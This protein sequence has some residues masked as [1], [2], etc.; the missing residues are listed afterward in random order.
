MIEAMA[1]GTPVIAFHSGSVPEVI[2]HGRS[3]FIVSSVEQAAEAVA[4]LDQIDRREV[5]AAFERR[6]TVER[7]AQDYLGIF[8]ILRRT[9][10]ASS[11]TSCSAG[12]MPRP[13]GSL[14]IS[15]SRRICSTRMIP[16][17]SDASA[18]HA[19]LHLQRRPCSS[20]PKASLGAGA[21]DSTAQG[22]QP[23][24]IVR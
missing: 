21:A 15:S 9:I 8:G 13:S 7:M 17:S 20:D 24:R 6:F 22:D 16:A 23:G 11:A 12:V 19:Q 1:C 14:R 2:D 10:S 18:G 4:H 3:G 5:R